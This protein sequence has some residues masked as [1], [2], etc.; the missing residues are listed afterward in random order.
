VEAVLLGVICS[1]CVV[2]GLTRWR[3]T[4]QLEQRERAVLRSSAH[5]WGLAMLPG[6]TTDE[7]R[8]R[9]DAAM[10]EHRSSDPI[11]TAARALRAQRERSQ[12]R[13]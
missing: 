11:E 4:Q 7:L 1:V 2:V 5:T 9:I 3:R 8:A 13:S 10:R 6:E 12:R